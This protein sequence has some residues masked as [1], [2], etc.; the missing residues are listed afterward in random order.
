VAKG[1]WETKALKKRTRFLDSFTERSK[2][3][4][5]KWRGSFLFLCRHKI[6]HASQ[7]G[8]DELHNPGKPQVLALPFQEFPALTDRRNLEFSEFPRDSLPRG[9]VWDFIEHRAWSFCREP[10]IP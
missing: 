1:I 9:T 8:I 6:S 7:E 10:A 2:L 3:R 4:V 5:Y